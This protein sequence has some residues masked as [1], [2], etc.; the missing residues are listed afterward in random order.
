MKI[1][2]TWSIVRRL[3]QENLVEV[4]LRKWYKL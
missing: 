1:P 3:S 2:N 4:I